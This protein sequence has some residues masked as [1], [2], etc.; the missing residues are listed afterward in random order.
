VAV[1]LVQE[2]GRHHLRAE[3][4]DGLAED[5]K[6]QN[7]LNAPRVCKRD[8]GKEKK[9]TKAESSEPKRTGRESERLQQ[10][11]KLGYDLSNRFSDARYY[12]S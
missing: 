2:I 10:F 9:M 7:F 4:N 5:S 3:R 12:A 11:H 6:A 8:K 1:E